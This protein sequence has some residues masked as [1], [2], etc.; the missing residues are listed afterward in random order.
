[1]SSER[2]LSGSVSEFDQSWKNLDAAERY[3]F[4]RSEPHHQ[5]QFA[6]QNNFRVFRKVM[7]KLTQGS[8]LEIGC[9]RGSMA[10]F[11]ADAGFD[12]HLLDTSPAAIDIARRNFAADGLAGKFSVGDALRLP[13]ADNSLD[14]T[15]SIGLLEHFENIRT[16]VEEQIRVLRKGGVFLG[17]VVPERPWSVQTLA[18]PVNRILAAAMEK[19]SSGSTIKTP[20]F[21]NDYRSSEYLSV[22]KSFGVEAT[23]AFGMFPLPLVS[24]SYSFPFSPMSSLAE[25]R[26]MRLWRT[27]LALRLNKSTESTSPTDDPWTCPEGWGL[28]FLVWA[29]K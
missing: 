13:Y 7:G 10:A 3:H 12:T 17:Y 11:F 4:V 19:R 2:Y 23:G 6:F 26:L 29:R 28:A 16:P 15:V 21:R 27:M 22:L 9:G 18:T 24:H 20:L 1:M 14:V 8:A 5:V 25:A